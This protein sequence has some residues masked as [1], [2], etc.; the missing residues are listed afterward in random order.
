VKPYREL[1]GSL[2]YAALIT[3]PDICT[4]INFYGKFQ[5]NAT[6]IHWKGLKRIHR[7]LKG[8][9]TVGLKYQR[10]DDCELTSFVDADWASHV[11]R[12]SVSGF[13]IKVYGNK[14]DWYTKKQST[15]SLSST[16]A[17]FN[18]L[19]EGLRELCWVNKALEEMDV[20]VKTPF[21]IYEDNQSCRDMIAGEWGQKRL[22]HMNIRYK[23]IKYWVELGFIVVNNINLENQEVDIFTKP[24]PLISFSKLKNGMTDSLLECFEVIGEMKA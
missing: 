7:Y 4:A 5:N 22:R 12:K 2:L 9:I 24:L 8:T 19:S 3:R 10:N 13:L 15:I 18:V 20:K 1:V 14:V 21:I 23:F 16:E 17:E 6:E 11:D